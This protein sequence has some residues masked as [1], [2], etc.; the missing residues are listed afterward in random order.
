MTPR[1][2]IIKKLLEKEDPITYSGCM[3][4]IY[5]LH[6]ELI[7]PFMKTFKESFLEAKKDLLQEPESIALL[8]AFQTMSA[9]AQYAISL[10]KT[11]NMQDAV[12]TGRSMATIIGYM[13]DGIGQ[14]NRSSYRSSIKLKLSQINDLD[15]SNAKMPDGAVIGQVLTF[16]KTILHGNDPLYIKNVLRT[17]AESI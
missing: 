12:G 6:P 5:K 13:L 14:E 9:T 15:V 4:T 2:K 7:A 17:I 1:S 8:E 11:A 16:V 10:M 3:R